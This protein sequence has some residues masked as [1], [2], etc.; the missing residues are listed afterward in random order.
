MVQ[1]RMCRQRTLSFLLA[2][3][4]HDV[5]LNFAFGVTLHVKLTYIR[6]TTGYIV[7]YMPMVKPK[8]GIQKFILP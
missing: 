2:Y 3:G 1:A 8:K 4:N 6:F 5:L 7:K